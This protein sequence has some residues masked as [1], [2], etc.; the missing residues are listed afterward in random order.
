MPK[1]TNEQEM[2]IKKSGSNI[3]VSAGA[4]SGKTAV[5]SE[6]VIEKIK[7]GIHV[8]ELLILT[9]TKAAASEMKDRIRKKIA[10]LDEYKDE[11]NLI[12]SSYITTFDSYALSVVKKYHYLL[13]IS[14]DIKITDESLVTLEKNKIIDSIFEELYKENNS[15]F[16][17]LIKDYCVKNDKVLRENILNIAD[18]VN[19]KIN[20]NE[21]LDF[22]KEYFFTDEYI[23]LL[24]DDYKSFINN[25]K[26]VIELELD[27]LSYYFEESLVDKV[28]EVIKPLI[29]CDINDLHLFSGIS[30]PRFKYP[31]EESKKVKERFKSLLDDLISF[32]SFNT[33]NDIRLNIKSNK[34]NINTIAL[35]VEKYINKLDNYKKLNNIYTFS[36]I[37]SLSIKLLKENES[38]REEIKNSF[39]E[40]MID[41]YQDTNDIQDI[42]ISLIENNNVYMVGDIKQSIYRFRGSNPNIFKDKYDKY[43]VNNGGIKID[44]IKNFRS[45]SEVL[46]NINDLFRLI[47]DDEIGGCNYKLSHEMIYGNTLYDDE[48]IKDFNYDMN[49]FEYDKSENYSNYEIEIFTIANDIKKKIESKMKVFDKETNKLRNINYNDFVIIL[50]RSKYFNE[51]K[52]VFEYLGIPLTILK[53]DVLNSNSDL[54]LI[55]NIIDFILRINNNDFDVS[56]KYDFISIARSFLYEYTDQY[57]FDVIKNNKYK[58]TTIYSDLSSIESI[59]SKTSN[60]LLYEVLCKT[61]FYE[62]INKIGDY[63]NINVRLETIYNMSLNLN[64]LGL[65]IE[66]FVD[67]LDELNNSGIDIKY[68]AYNDSENSVKIMTIHASKGLEYPICYFS[69]LDHKFNLSDA[70]NLIVTSSKYGLLI[71][72]LDEDNDKNI[73][74]ILYRYDY[75][76]EEISEKIRL[77][78]V[79]LTRAREKIII[80]LP[81]KDTIK[82]EKDD[83]GVIDKNRRLDFIKLSDLIY[84]I[85]D[86][87]INY[88][89]DVDISNINLT[90]DYLFNKSISRKLVFES[91]K[92]DVKEIS[93]ENEILDEKHFSKETSLLTKED[94]NNML[95]GT[96]IHEILEYIDFKNYNEELIKDKMIRNKI[97]KLLNSKLFKDIKNANIYKEY[98]F[99]YNI[100]N[101]KYHGIIDLMIEH[102]DYIDIVDYKLKNLTE[103][104][105]LN[106]L[107]G[108]KN[109]ISSLTNKKVNLY[110]YSILDETVE[111]I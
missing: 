25:K 38:I 84:A 31:S 83:N 7:N 22:I 104:K 85:K 23:D 92:L 58:Q 81:K 95:Y 12:N 90:K 13:N 78:Y 6:R 94:R 98:E 75:L 20:K 109:Y 19:D 69:D 32:G 61:N 49:I 100:D 65:S 45:R 50:D 30:L 40:I 46:N 71:P 77:F 53:D 72:S 62:K 82:L 59:N 15:D 102:D 16:E 34:K 35:I 42:F 99:V 57:I 107:N 37:A 18:K 36:D 54:L 66:E 111:S 10:K 79:A 80:V 91:D 14:N 89:S 44:L 67:Y 1:W 56:F 51:Y 63:N 39:K 11:L 55:K 88:F 52:K 41:E 21:Y 5:L 4:G 108:Y 28:R 64:N 93:I 48:K 27:N 101:I 43:S 87:L 73:L 76:K 3:I 106:Q 96:K 86:Y 97:S 17:S 105:Y 68:N 47:M 26:R 33:L 110:L 103:E 24:L 29:E 70:N 9:F 8:N 74:K 2:A 60:E